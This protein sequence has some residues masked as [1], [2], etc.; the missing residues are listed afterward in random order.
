MYYLY[1]LR[2][3]DDSLYT[4]I[5]TDPKRRLKEHKKNIGARYTRS[6]GAD[7]IVHLERFPTRS[8][9]SKR[10]FEVK[11]LRREKKLALIKSGKK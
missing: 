6:R 1:I 9:A 2:C 10:E 3:K 5:T 11:Q 8:A 4:G 7:K